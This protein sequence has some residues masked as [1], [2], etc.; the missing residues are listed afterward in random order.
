MIMYESIF[1]VYATFMIVTF[2]MGFILGFA[3]GFKH[4]TKSM[5]S[6]T[7]KEEKWLKP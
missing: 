7:I 5:V 1:I 6:Q 3:F 4:A 2:V